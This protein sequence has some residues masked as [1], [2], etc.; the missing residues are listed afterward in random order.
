M[1]LSN[2]IEQL[3]YRDLTAEDA[4]I[5]GETEQLIYGADN[6]GLINGLLDI[7]NELQVVSKENFS[8]GAFDSKTGRLVGYV[9][10][11]RERSENS[12]DKETV[13]N[14]VST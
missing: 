4:Q 1:K 10:C 8:I 9:I 13:Q 5:I 7:K 3:E 11:Y 12:E 2:S 6:P 14:F